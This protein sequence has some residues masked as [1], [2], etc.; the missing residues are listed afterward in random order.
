MSKVIATL[1]THDFED[2]EYAETVHAY[3]AAG[4][5]VIN[6]EYF[7]GHVVHGLQRKT[8]TTIDAAIGHTNVQHFDALFIPGGH[9]PYALKKDEQ[10][11]TFVQKFANM[12]KPIFI[13]SHALQLLMHASVILGRRICTH[14][15]ITNEP[16]HAGAVCLDQDI[17]NDNNLYVSSRVAH[18]CPAFVNETLKVLNL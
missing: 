2:M 8:S 1:V 12:Q 5:S 3:R 15:S 14:E 6:I 13:C 10:F 4:H 17:V 7:E 11:I 9:S 16:S 18:H